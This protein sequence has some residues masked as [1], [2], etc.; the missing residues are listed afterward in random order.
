M[1]RCSRYPLATKKGGIKNAYTNKVENIH[2]R[3]RVNDETENIQGRTA[4]PL[5]RSVYRPLALAGH[6]IGTWTIVP[7]GEAAPEGAT[8][9][10]R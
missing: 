4:H 8:G 6:L 9:T 10:P 2:R 5:A 7:C 1:P 3:S